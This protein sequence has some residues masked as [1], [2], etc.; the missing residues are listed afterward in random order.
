[1]TDQDRRKKFEELCE[2]ANFNLEEY[3]KKEK[4]EK[5]HLDDRWNEY[6][7]IVLKYVQENNKLP[8]GTDKQNNGKWLSDQK[9]QYKNFKTGTGRQ[10]MTDQDRRKKFEELCELANNFDLEK[11]CKK[12][13][14]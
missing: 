12:E 4:K 1:M 3:C 5:K 14:K 6:Y 13:K 8:T 2:L 9:T 7:Q 11:F 10:K